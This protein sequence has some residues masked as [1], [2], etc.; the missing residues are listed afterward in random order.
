[1]RTR[2]IARQANAIRKKMAEAMKTIDDLEV[3]LKK[4]QSQC[5][6]PEPYHIHHGRQIA[7]DDPWDEC[8]ACR[9]IW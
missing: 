6:H 1:M 3:D 7:E 4:L 8:L 5:T 2:E 9:K